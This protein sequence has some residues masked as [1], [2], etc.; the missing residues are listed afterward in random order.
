[1]LDKLPELFA[2]GG[3]V[4]AEAHDWHRELLAAR[5]NEYDPRVSVRIRRGTLLSSA[6]YLFL[7]RLRRELI[8]RWSEQSA[9]FDAVVMP[10][11]PILAPTVQE[12]SDDEVYGRINF[13]WPD[14]GRL[15]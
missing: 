3:I 2:N 10:T 11:V 5:G 9:A 14:R 15:S 12:L 8:A 1:M 6:D 4:A 13:S 7:Q